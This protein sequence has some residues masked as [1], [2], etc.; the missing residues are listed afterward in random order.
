MFSGRFIHIRIYQSRK[1]YM[2]DFIME[3]VYTENNTLLT[4]EKNILL[5]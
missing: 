4:F 2:K 3:T 5:N 1:K